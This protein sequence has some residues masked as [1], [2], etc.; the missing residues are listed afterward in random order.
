MRQFQLT[1]SEIA[2]LGGAL[3]VTC[4]G[5]DP[6]AQPGQ[7]LLALANGAARPHPSTPPLLRLPLFYHT[8]PGGGAQ[9]YLPPGHPLSSLVPGDVLDLL[10]PVGRGFR[11]P[12]RGSHLLVVAAAP[13]RLLP[14][15][16]AALEAGLAVTALTPR[17]ADLLPSDVELHR[18]PLTAELAQWAD[19]VALDVADPRAR[20]QHIRSL[21]PPRGP[22][23]IQALVVPPLP[24]GTGA[25]QACW[26]ELT[27][28]HL[29]K[30]ACVDGPVFTF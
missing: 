15:I 29:R 2:A 17:S 28:P 11:L 4:A 16:E 27:Q 19:L 6:G 26:V 22:E 10:G 25:C 5:P 12:R 7:A 20:A 24:C 1:V 13:E 21:A 14:L 3:R 30:L 18:G 8:L 9:C 23:Y